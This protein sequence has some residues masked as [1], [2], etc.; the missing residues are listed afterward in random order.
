M[1]HVRLSCIII[2]CS[3][4]KAQV[5]VEW[6]AFGTSFVYNLPILPFQSPIVLDTWA[7]VGF[8]AVRESVEREGF[9]SERV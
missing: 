9:I 2:G 7:I 4:Q 5:D 6:A 3:T 1:H 8:T